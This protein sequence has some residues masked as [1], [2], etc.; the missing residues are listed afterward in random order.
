M[1]QLHFTLWAYCSVSS[2]FGEKK[3]QYFCGENKVPYEKHLKLYSRVPSMLQ[4]EWVASYRGRSHRFLHRDR[5]S[6]PQLHRN[7]LLRRCA[8]DC[9]MNKIINHYKRNNKNNKQYTENEFDRV[10]NFEN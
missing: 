8:S 2:A 10:Q 1:F 6:T 3:L 9:R 7:H 5:V 4:R